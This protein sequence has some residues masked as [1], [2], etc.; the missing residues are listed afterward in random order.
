LRSIDSFTVDIHVGKY[1]GAFPAQTLLT[2]TVLRLQS[3]YQRN[4]LQRTKIL[5]RAHSRPWGTSFM[6]GMCKVNG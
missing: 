6:W 1:S 3:K 2:W 5:T 4:P